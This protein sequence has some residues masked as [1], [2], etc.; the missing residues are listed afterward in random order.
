MT[1]MGGSLFSH[2]YVGEI[3]GAPCGSGIAPNDPRLVG[4]EGQRTDATSQ[5]GL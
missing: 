4:G 1:A 2:G 5:L 3:M